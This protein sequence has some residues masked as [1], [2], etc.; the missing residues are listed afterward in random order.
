MTEPRIFTL[1]D[2]P[3]L[4]E[5]IELWDPQG[6]RIVWT[7]K[8]WYDPQDSDGSFQTQEAWPPDGDGPWV[9]RPKAPLLIVYAVTVAN[10][11]PPEVVAI[12]DNE[13]AARAHADADD[14]DLGLTVTAWAVGSEFPA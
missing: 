7:G 6:Y 8:R 3:P 4:G 5:R 12:Y 14:S 10:Y 2:S 13:K 11:E 9:D 1:R